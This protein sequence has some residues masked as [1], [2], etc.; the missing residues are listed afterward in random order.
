MTRAFPIILVALVAIEAGTAA[1]M[2]EPRGIVFTNCAVLT[3]PDYDQSELQEYVTP[4]LM[5]GFYDAYDDDIY[6][7]TTML[8]YGELELCVSWD[9][10]EEPEA[11]RRMQQT[12]YD[13]RSDLPIELTNIEYD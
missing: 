2:Q 13:L 10:I 8:D 9:S 1:A 11:D 6:V 5:S 4:I 12:L 3:I 7:I